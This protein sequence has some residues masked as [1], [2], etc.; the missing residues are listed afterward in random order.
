MLAQTSPSSYWGMEAGGIGYFSNAKEK[1][2]IRKEFSQTYYFNNSDDAP[3]SYYAVYAGFKYERLIKQDRIGL[4]TG[5]RVTKSHSD[6]KGN[7]SWLNSND[8]FYV[9]YRSENTLTE[10][11]KVKEISQDTYY[12][13]LPLEA[14]YLLFSPR[15]F[16]LYFKLGVQLN[17]RVSSS[18]DFVF[19]D[20]DMEIYQK[21]L[22]DRIGEPNVFSSSF[23]GGVGMRFGEDSNPAVSIELTLPAFTDNNSSTLSSPTVGVGAQI[24]IQIP[25]S[26]NSKNL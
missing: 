18:N 9:V 14:R 19:V 21:E 23:Y 7:D 15:F 4:M 5:L 16:R 10:Y 13:G 3:S 26:N 25:Y 17:F 1:D 20:R 2:Y 12:M 8:F 6:R 22:S 11:L 24:N